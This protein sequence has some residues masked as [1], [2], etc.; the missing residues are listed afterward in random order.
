ML[1]HMYLYIL[2]VSC[3][4]NDNA[5]YCQQWLNQTFLKF[6]YEFHSFRKIRDKKVNI[7]YLLI[8]FGTKHSYGFLYSYFHFPIFFQLMYFSA[9]SYPHEGFLRALSVSCGHHMPRLGKLDPRPPS[10]SER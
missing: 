2:H 1:I 9:H 8:Y 5:I 6:C 10:V 7:C 3:S 4:F